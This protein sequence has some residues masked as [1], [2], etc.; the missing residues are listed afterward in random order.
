M[1][2]KLLWILTRR[3][4]PDPPD[5]K[6]NALKLDTSQRFER[7]SCPKFFLPVSAHKLDAE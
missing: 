5:P 7:S 3:R 6:N 2:E 4:A 1:D